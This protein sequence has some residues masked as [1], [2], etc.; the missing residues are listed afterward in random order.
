MLHLSSNALHADWNIERGSP[1]SNGEDAEKTGLLS[2]KTLL[3]VLELACLPH[4]VERVGGLDASRNWN[5]ILSQGEQQRIAFARLFLQKPSLV[6]CDEATSAVDEET[7]RILYAR[8]TKM[9]KS[10]ISVAHRSTL[11]KFHQL[12]LFKGSSA[13]SSWA[14]KDIST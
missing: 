12:V 7:E 13:A 4:L 8:L 3:H 2:D 11:K 6:F 5:Q 9:A 10:V 1:L 14:V